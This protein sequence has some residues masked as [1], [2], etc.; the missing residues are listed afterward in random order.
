MAQPPPFVPKPEPLGRYVLFLASGLGWGARQAACHSDDLDDLLMAI[1]T[2]ED[3]E[4]EPEPVV[5]Q[6]F[7]CETGRICASSDPERDREH[8]AIPGDGGLLVFVQSE[9]PDWG[10]RCITGR[11]GI[12][13]GSSQNLGMSNSTIFEAG[14]LV[15][16]VP[17]LGSIEQY[18][19]ELAQ[20]ETEQYAEPEGPPPAD[21]PPGDVLHGLPPGWEEMS[22]D[23]LRAWVEEQEAKATPVQ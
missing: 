23:E 17:S 1:P 4:G 22:N 21:Q 7:D 16:I 12:A 20:W 9:G 3:T 19:I 8:P 10:A 13:P 11:A 15:G 5:W 2:I 18:Q 6:V 14:K